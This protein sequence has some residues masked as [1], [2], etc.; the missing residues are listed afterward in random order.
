MSCMQL[1]KEHIRELAVFYALHYDRKPLQDL[2][3][4]QGAFDEL[5]ELNAIAYST[6][7]R[8]QPDPEELTI[9]EAHLAYRKVTDPVA[10]LSMTNC[11]EYQCIDAEDEYREHRGAKIIERIKESAIRMLPGYDNAP[12]CYT[13]REEQEDH[14]TEVI[15]LSVMAANMKKRTA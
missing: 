13:E 6:R 2:T 3:R 14:K 7:Y 15:S 12:W 5:A 1:P 10:I 11:L 4:A 9:R 8:E